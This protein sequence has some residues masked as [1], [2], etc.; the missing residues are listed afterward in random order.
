MCHVYRDHNIH[1]CLWHDI[2]NNYDRYTMMLKRG[3]G[4]RVKRRYMVQEQEEVVTHS[5]YIKCSTY[6]AYTVRFVFPCSS[7]CCCR[8]VCSL[9]WL[10][11][12]A[13]RRTW[14]PLQVPAR[15]HFLPYSFLQQ[16][17]VGLFYCRRSY[18]S[19]QTTGHGVFTRP[20][21]RT[22]GFLLLMSTRISCLG[23]SMAYKRHGFA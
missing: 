22:S 7:E 2:Q 14:H 21:L 23:G 19:W 11:S 17:T 3:D 20:E 8:V 18:P 16:G 10:V 4:K 9:L 15:L 6:R 1:G 5:Q 12:T 13:W